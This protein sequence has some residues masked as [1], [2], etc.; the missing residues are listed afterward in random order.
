MHNFF[1]EKSNQKMWPISVII[2]KN[3]RP[4]GEISPNRVTLGHRNVLRRTYKNGCHANDKPTEEFFQ[5]ISMKIRNC[6]LLLALAGELT[7]MLNLKSGKSRLEAII[8]YFF[9][10]LTQPEG[11]S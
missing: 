4:K 1:R 6:L 7:I 5:V 8:K 10:R 11:C 9:L 2:K 3:D